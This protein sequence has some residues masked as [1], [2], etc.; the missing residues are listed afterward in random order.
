[1]KIIELKAENIRGLK[2]IELKP[3]SN[4]VELAGK[5]GQG[6]SSV[7][8]AIW[9]ALGGGA[10]TKEITTPLRNGAETGFVDLDL[11]TLRVRRNFTATG[12]TSLKVTMIQDGVKSN[13]SSPQSVLD[14]LRAV[15]LDPAGF[16][17]LEPKK[18]REEL[19]GLL[20]LE[21]DLDELAGQRKQLYEARTEVGRQ[22]KALGE[23]P[24][25]D[26][27][28]P[29]VEQSAS[30]IIEQIEKINEQNAERKNAD[31]E[32]SRMRDAID[33]T[34]REIESLERQI[35]ELEDVRRKQQE[36]LEGLFA[37]RAKLPEY[38]GTED[39]RAKLVTVEE[40]NAKIRANNQAREKSALKDSLTLKWGELTKQI[41]ALDAKRNA[42]ISN[43]NLPVEGLDI[44]ETDLVLNGVPFG[45]VNPGHQMRAALKIIAALNPK[46]RIIQVRQG[47]LIDED[48]RREIEEFAQENDFQIWYETVGTG[49]GNA[50]T[51]EAGK[52]L[53]AL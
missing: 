11:G 44:A 19:L 7:L 13:V 53:E 37:Q 46:L 52:I 39:L 22:G 18:R 14:A 4:F 49:G 35:S 12:T 30:E 1:M 17:A 20:N 32:V 21:V 23:V 47:S 6:K 51:I 42:A 28:L 33:D 25:I 40:V 8:D 5:N 9:L 48:G 15:A 34:G 43:A 38:S 41:D 2:A 27:E 3:S 24:P 50:I 29:T 26:P 45:E 10:A 36:S 16:I 31:D